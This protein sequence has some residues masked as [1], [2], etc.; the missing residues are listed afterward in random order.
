MKKEVFISICGGL[1]FSLSTQTILAD[2]IPSRTLPMSEIL[3]IL[4][5][6]GYSVIREVEFDD[7]LY[8]VE[9]FDE[10][11]IQLI[12]RMNPN[13]G[14]FINTNL[15]TKK[16][17]ISMLEAAQRIEGAGYHT[18]FKIEAH[19]SQYE[20]KALGTEDKKIKLR[21]DANSGKI[22]ILE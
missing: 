21:I 6:R 22:Y 7:G 2:E 8:E 16:Y 15:K 14:D 1:I 17:P 5:T 11:G 3:K 12:I 13:T 20:A 18:I 9:A 10:K 4:Q 19:G